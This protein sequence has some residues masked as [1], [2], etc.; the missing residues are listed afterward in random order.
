MKL[1]VFTFI[2]CCFSLVSNFYLP[3]VAPNEYAEDDPVDLKVNKLTSSRTQ[4][5]YDYYSLPFCAPNPII[6]V[7]EN[8]GE[9]LFGERIKN[10]LYEIRANKSVACKIL[11]VT[12]YDSE[13]AK[14]FSDKI[15]E[16]YKISWLL[17]NLPAAIKKTYQDANGDKVAYEEGFPLGQKAEGTDDKST[18]LNNHVDLKILF[19]EVPTQ[20]K[21]RIVGFEVEPDSIKYNLN[22]IEQTCSQ[23]GAAAKQLISPQEKNTTVAW[24][25]SVTWEQSPIR[26]ASRWDLYLRMTDDQIHW[27]SIINSCMI[28]LFLT[29]MVAMIMMRTLNADFRRYR[30]METQ[31]EAQEETG[32]KLVHGDVFRPPSNPML[33]SVL[34]GSGIQIIACTVV[35]MAFAVIGFLSPAN[36]GALM[37]AMLVLFVVMG[38]FA[39]YYSARFYKL[40]KGQ[41]DRKQNTI[42]TAFFVPGV[43]FSIFL[44]LDWL[45]MSQKSSGHV[46][47]SIFLALVG[48][49]FGVSVPL[50]F[51]GSYFG[52]KKPTIEN[53]VRTNQIP[54][55]I[56]EQVWY[57]RPFFSILMGGILPFG[58]VFIELF[59]IMSSIWLHQFYYLFG[60]LLIVFVIL[61]LTCAEITIVMC[62]F[63]LCSEDYHWWWRSFLTSGASAFYMFLYSVFYF[64]TKLQIVNVV[65][66]ILYFGYTL[67]M[68]IFFFVLTGT[69]GFVAC[70]WFVR[71]IYSSIKID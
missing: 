25:Y 44:F 39:G 47:F 53:P 33:L 56:P 38:I 29:G 31:E 57:M 55:Q 28:V 48:L 54:R 1:L 7:A 27:F 37:T 14:L 64:F 11:C 70:F 21:L 65:G 42:M 43:V 41:V 45:I 51:F 59:F 23:R 40:F 35:T 58:A 66:G 60:F 67:I 5:P 20:T 4:L 9:I 16:D 18:F 50:T 3:G 36:R 30:E 34:V 46:P 49:W 6:A 10:S 71:K 8:L 12:S 15:A 17:D 62:Y 32:W 19:H 69:I 52:Y 61:I 68:T 24:T 63:Q 22:N 26:W 13:Q 2:F